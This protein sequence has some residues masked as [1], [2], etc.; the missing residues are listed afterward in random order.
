MK[1]WIE[2]LNTTLNSQ[3]NEG[4]K[5]WGYGHEYTKQMNVQW[6]QW[7]SKQK[8]SLWTCI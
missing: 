8:V 7:E 4:K 5:M 3:H 2:I 1:W 6:T